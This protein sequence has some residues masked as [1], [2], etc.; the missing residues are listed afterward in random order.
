MA[1]FGKIEEFDSAN[2]DWP[3]YEEQLSHYFIANVIENP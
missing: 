1:T 2:E 3:Q